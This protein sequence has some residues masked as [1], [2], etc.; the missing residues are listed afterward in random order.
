MEEGAL[1]AVKVI[2]AVPKYKSAAKIEI[3]ILNKLR[4]AADIG[5]SYVLL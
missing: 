2:R 4:A 3:D 5:T 1:Y